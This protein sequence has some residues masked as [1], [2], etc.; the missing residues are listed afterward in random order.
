MA[1]LT[2]L[3]AA[4]AP[5]RAT[6]RAAAQGPSG[7]TRV[8]SSA[9][10]AAPD[11]A[12]ELTIAP[13]ETLSI[14][15]TG[16]GPAVVLVPGLFGAAFGFRGIVPLLVQ[17]RYRAVVIEPLGI[18]QSSRPEGADYSLAAQADRL[19]A[20]LHAL[21]L[22]DV[23][24]IAH[25]LGAAEAFRL[26]YRHPGLVRGLIS[27]E[28]GPAEQTSTPTFRRAIRLAS[29]FH[30]FGGL[31]L[32]RHEIRRSLVRSSGD[33]TWVTDGAVQGY[34]T[35]AAADLGSMLKGYLKMATAREPEPLAPHLAEIRAPVRLLVGSSVHEGGISPD[36]IE[37]LAHALPNFAV[38]TVPGAGH[39]IQEERPERILASLSLLEQTLRKTP[40]DPSPR[41]SR[42]R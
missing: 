9:S 12:Q 16:T 37:L 6:L 19:A 26:A 15:S 36:Q 5:C 40:S 4:G 35:A 11:H 18:G 20:A 2:S 24:V 30:V 39:F 25:S 29:W 32:I 17:A 42:S 3:V 23:I 14:E 21:R 7:A 38:D 10:D 8:R 31:K 22:H 1:G 27:I 41:P 13:D 34:T 28:G 33:S